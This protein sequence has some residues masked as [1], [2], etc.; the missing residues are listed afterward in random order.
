[1][2][3]IFPNEDAVIRLVGPIKLEQNCEMGSAAR[4]SVSLETTAPIGDD[5]AVGLPATLI[6]STEQ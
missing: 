2:L 6:R 3:T 5:T 1:V 4:R